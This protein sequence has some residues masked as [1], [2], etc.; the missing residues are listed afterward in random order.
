MILAV[1]FLIATSSLAF[2]VPGAK[3]ATITIENNIAYGHHSDNRLDARYD[4]SA[5]GRP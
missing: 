1:A 5:T 3:A 4:A 2:G